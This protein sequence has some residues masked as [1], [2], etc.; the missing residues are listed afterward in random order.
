MPPRTRASV[1]DIG[2]DEIYNFRWVYAVQLQRWT[3][4][5]PPAKQLRE[6]L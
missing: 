3:C 1:V 5:E 2:S 4:S 6:Y